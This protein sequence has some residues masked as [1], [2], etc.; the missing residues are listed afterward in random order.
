MPAHINNGYGDFHEESDR[1]LS[2]KTLD[3]ECARSQEKGRKGKGL[4]QQ[5]MNESLKDFNHGVEIEE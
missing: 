2:G 5:T 1:K 4:N 3:A